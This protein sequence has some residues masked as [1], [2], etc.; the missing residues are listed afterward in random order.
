MSESRGKG[1][2]MQWYDVHGGMAQRN[3]DFMTGDGVEVWSDTGN[4]ETVTI[5]PAKAVGR[6]F[7]ALTEATGRTVSGRHPCKLVVAPIMD[8][9]EITG[10]QIAIEPTDD[11]M[12]LGEFRQVATAVREVYQA[13]GDQA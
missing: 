6:A 10:T 4:L 2:N 7:E 11:A 13:S 9:G 5:N 3:I 8:N 1:D 12:T